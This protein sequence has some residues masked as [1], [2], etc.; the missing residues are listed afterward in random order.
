[1]TLVRVLRRAGVGIRLSEH[2]DGD[3]VYRHACKLGLE[4][5]VSKRYDAPY[6]SGRSPH[7]MKGEDPDGAA[8]K[9]IAEIEW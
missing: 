1:M 6:R 8:A 5:I 3:A 2:L 7:R 4:E 9:R